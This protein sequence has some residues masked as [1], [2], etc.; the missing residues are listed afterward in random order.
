MHPDL[1]R[2]HVV[3]IR[4]SCYNIKPELVGVFWL[5]SVQVSSNIPSGFQYS[6]FDL[7]GP[8]KRRTHVSSL[9]PRHIHKP[10]LHV[11]MHIEEGRPLTT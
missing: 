3:G 1:H 9:K 11:H 7:V 5:P 2:F 8:V 6:D 4:F 10:Y